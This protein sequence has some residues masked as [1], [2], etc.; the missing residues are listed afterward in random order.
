MDPWL[1]DD[2]KESLFRPCLEISGHIG[3]RMNN[4]LAMGQELDERTLTDDFID[5]FDTSSSSNAWGPTTQELRD[6]QIY[7]QLSVRKSTVE[8]RTGADVGL[9]LRRNTHGSRRTSASYAC[10]VQCKRVDRAGNIGD[11]YH[12]VASTGRRQS[13]LMLEVT[14]SSFYFVFVPPALVDHYCNIEPLAFIKAGPGCSVPAWNLGLFAQEGVSV[15]FLGGA[16]KEK[17]CG[18]LVV[19]A[20]AVEAQ[21]PTGKAASL[22]SILPNCLPLWYWFGQLFVPGFVG[23]PS[24][25]T[26][27]VARNVTAR[28]TLDVAFGVRYSLEISLGNG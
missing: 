8:H 9:I 6:H 5:C 11:F 12:Q 21:Q 7:L 18:V 13:S 20:L 22:L 2:I 17:V 27:N 4:R 10:L 3:R 19:P 16:D 28:E 15:P 26:M 1:T 25:N 23:D 24:V 14:P